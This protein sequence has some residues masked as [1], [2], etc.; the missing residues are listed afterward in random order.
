MS[1]QNAAVV[2]EEVLR[3]AMDEALSLQAKD[4]LNDADSAALMAYFNILDWGKQQADIMGVKFADQE[5]Q[6][7]DPYRLLLKKVA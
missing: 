4:Y 7:F 1:Q 5:L 2:L 3:S 6:G